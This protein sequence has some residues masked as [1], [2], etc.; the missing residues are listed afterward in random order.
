MAPPREV[1][2]KPP[3]NVFRCYPK[4]PHK[5]NKFTLVLSVAGEEWQVD[6]FGCPESARAGCHLPGCVCT[7]EAL[8]TSKRNRR[9]L[10]LAVGQLKDYP[11]VLVLAVTIISANFATKTDVTVKIFRRCTACSSTN[12]KTPSSSHQNVL[13]H[14]CWLSVASKKRCKYTSVPPRV[15]TTIFAMLPT[16]IRPSILVRFGFERLPS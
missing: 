14:A 10:A 8:E 3:A 4:L 5:R 11:A 6:T 12:R 13:R 1:S 16:S 15:D 7:L 9:S 2:Q